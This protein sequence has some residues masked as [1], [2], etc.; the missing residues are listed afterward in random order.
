MPVELTVL[1]VDMAV[2]CGY[3][4]LNGGPGAPAFL[5]VARR[6]Q[7]AL[8]QP[9][10]GW[11]GH[12]DPFAFSD[13]FRPAPDIKRAQSGTQSVLGM[14]ALEV[15][16]DTAL[17]VDMKLVRE[18]SKKL[19]NLLIDLVQ[20]SCPDLT[21]ASPQEEDCRGSHV[22]I[23]HDRGYSITRALND[24]GIVVDFR[25]P[26]IIRF[27]FAPL[28]TSY[29]DIW[30]TAECLEQ[31]LRTRAWDREEFKQQATVT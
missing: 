5:Y 23:R 1:D 11:W 19:G 7:T 4:Y 3:K 15:G 24:R 27:G 13:E 18:K 9:L 25:A 30:N 20:Q 28:Y 14:A 10:S 8:H 2:G 22:A 31:I 21:L 17:S 16:I 12:A 6:L 29:M 26:D